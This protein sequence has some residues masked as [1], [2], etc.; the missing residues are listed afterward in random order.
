MQK[1][2][3]RRVAVTGY[4]AVSS[5]GNSSS[6][7]WDSIVNYRIGYQQESFPE[8]RIVARFFGMMHNKPPRKG[9]PKAIMKFLPEFAL[10][11]MSAAAEAL[12]M[13]F[14]KEK[15]L[16]EIYDPF[17]RGVIFGTGWSAL[18]ESTKENTSYREEGFASLSPTCW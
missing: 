18:D 4:G 11:G 17:D 10:L 14:G 8:S 13:A 12:V 9:F 3:P 5:L 16:D 2:T 6:E 15:P 7:I 1:N